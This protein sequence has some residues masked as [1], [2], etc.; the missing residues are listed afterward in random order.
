MEFTFRAILSQEERRKSAAVQAVLHIGAA[1]ILQVVRDHGG[2]P[3]FDFATGQRIP[4]FGGG[5][6]RGR[7]GGD[8]LNIGEM[9]GCYLKNLRWIGQ[10]MNLVENKPF[11]LP[12][13]QE[14]FRIFQKT[15]GPGS[16]QSKY[17]VSGKDWQRNVFPTR[18]TPE[19]QRTDLFFQD[20][21]IRF[22]QK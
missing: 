13:I 5:S 20:A 7:A 4:E 19:S 14:T 3:D 16:S 11:P 17:S 2:E 21:S 15:A 1:K 18:L 6:E 12:A 9:I 8:N 22:S 10:T